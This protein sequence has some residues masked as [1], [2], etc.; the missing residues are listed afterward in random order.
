M[1]AQFERLGLAVERIEAISPDL[2]TA[3]QLARYTDQRRR[4]WASPQELCCSLSHHAALRRLLDSGE[5]HALILE[6]DVVL[7]SA[8]PSIL[9]HPMP[10]CDVLRLETFVIP[11]HL[12]ARPSGTMQ[13]FELFQLHGW[14]WGT[15]AYVASR[16]AAE[17]ILHAEAALAT[18]YDRV[19]FN[20]YRPPGAAIQTLQTVPAL[21]VQLHRHNAGPLVSDIGTNQPDKTMK[22]WGLSLAHSLASWWET[23]I[24]MGVPKT[25]NRALRRTTRTIIPFAET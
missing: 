4:R 6:D 25:L 16:R 9:S 11:Q 13:H 15:A 21:A 19:L 7:S 22:P 24:R 20:R 14:T 1:E 23:E 12:S 18:P 8:L 2:L 3:T 5:S 10:D 17:I